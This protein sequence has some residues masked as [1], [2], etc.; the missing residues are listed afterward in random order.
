ME[1]LTGKV[2]ALE[3]KAKVQ[4]EKIHE[5]ENSKTD[6]TKKSS[7][8]SEKV[9][10]LKLSAVIDSQLWKECKSHYNKHFISFSSVDIGI[11]RLLAAGKYCFER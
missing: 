6:E 7:E 1:E 8:L 9:T 4:E 10:T 2:L 5:E 3:E 11:R